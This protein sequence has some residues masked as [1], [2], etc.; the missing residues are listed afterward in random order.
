MI[1]VLLSKTYLDVYNNGARHLQLLRSIPS[2]A[3]LTNLVGMK[4]NAHLRQNLEVSQKPL[5][6]RQEFFDF[7]Q[8]A[9]RREYIEDDLSNM[10]D[11]KEKFVQQ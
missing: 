6:S 11:D 3:L 9:R 7:M 2:A 5:L 1:D 4:T 10:T 8:P